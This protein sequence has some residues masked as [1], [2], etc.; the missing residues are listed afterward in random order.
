MHEKIK[1][2]SLNKK[3]IHFKSDSSMLKNIAVVYTAYNALLQV[4][5]RHV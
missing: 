5:V 4:D 1:Y 2:T 3:L